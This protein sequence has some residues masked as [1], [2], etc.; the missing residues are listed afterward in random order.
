MFGTLG[1]KA[2]FAPNMK[3][4]LQNSDEDSD[5]V[6]D[7]EGSDLS[8]LG[9]LD[10]APVQ[11]LS[12][13]R[14]QSASLSVRGSCVDNGAQLSDTSSLT[15]IV[16]KWSTDKSTDTIQEQEQ[17]PER[18]QELKEKSNDSSLSPLT[19]EDNRTQG[20]KPKLPLNRVKRLNLQQKLDLSQ[21]NV[22]DR[23]GRTQLFRY[24]ERGDL[25]SCRQLL[26]ANADVNVSD[27]AGWRPLHL[28]CARG[29]SSIVKLFLERGADPHARGLNH[30][31]ALHDAALSGDLESV[32]HLVQLGADINARNLDGQS[33]M[34]LCCQPECLEFMRERL[35]RNREINSQ[36]KDGY[37]RLHLAC[38]EGDVSGVIQLLLEGADVNVTDFHLATPMHL[39]AQRGQLKIIAALVKRGALVDLQDKNGNTSLHLATQH[40]QLQAVKLLL[41]NRSNPLVRN[42]F[43]Q[44]PMDLC[45]SEVIAGMLREH[46]ITY[47]TRAMD[48][49]VLLPRANKALP[50]DGCKSGKGKL[51]PPSSSANRNLT[52]SHLD[53]HGAASLPLAKNHLASSPSQLTDP[54]TPNTA[55]LDVDISED[56]LLSARAEL[57]LQEALGFSPLY[58]VR[59]PAAL[60]LGYMVLDFQV[61]HLL[62]LPHDS[63]LGQYPHLTRCK[64]TARQKERMWPVMCQM[65]KLNK[66]NGQLTQEEFLQAL[67][68]DY[69][70]LGPFLECVALDINYNVSLSEAGPELPGDEGFPPKEVVIRDPN[71]AAT[72]ETSLPTPPIR[73]PPHSELELKGP[74]AYLLSL[75]TFLQRHPR[76]NPRPDLPLREAARCFVNRSHSHRS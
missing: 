2:G 23:A 66:M 46:I 68:K 61:Q 73:R 27:N 10:S 70:Q 16:S 24:A 22:R 1:T 48:M 35:D 67:N 9:G 55:L 26:D 31:T 71:S 12:V 42:H 56:S 25:G 5:F 74:P 21:P 34:D 50:S 39:A 17:R 64:L 63:L 59:L 6:S 3:E 37:S 58:C 45:K 69:P 43:N 44:L 15:D 19:S 76:L 41:E 32:R 14:S 30:Q 38:I 20:F 51:A 53:T 29:A 72:S 28:A 18:E 8:S 57:E 62:R 33:A 4:I 36:N 47:S 60:Q 7:F 49:D 13:S 54:Y 11:K 65:L 75:T 52:H 40:S